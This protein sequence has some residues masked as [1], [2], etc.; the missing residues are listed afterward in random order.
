M[1]RYINNLGIAIMS[2]V[3]V[4]WY[5]TIYWPKLSYS[6]VTTID[7]IISKCCIYHN[8]SMKSMVTIIVIHF[9][10]ITAHG[11]TTPPHSHQSWGVKNIIAYNQAL[12]LTQDGEAKRLSKNCNTRDF[13]ERLE[14]RWVWFVFANF[15]PIYMCDEPMTWYG[16]STICIKACC[17]I[18]GPEG[19]LDL[20]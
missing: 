1:G 8:N 18:Y 12:P 4:L 13:D 6:Y 11:S 19:W 17:I 7:L 20:K 16:I 5:D 15:H 2:I 3:I 14:P 9:P 10:T